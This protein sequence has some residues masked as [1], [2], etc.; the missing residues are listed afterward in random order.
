MRVRG[1]LVMAALLLSTCAKTA[2]PTAVA[3]EYSRALYAGEPHAIYRLIS[4]EDQRLRSEVDF[5]QQQEEREGF[6]G[7]L[8]AQLAS[9]IVAT[10]VETRV[11]NRRATVRLKLVLPNANA[12]EIRALAHD[13]DEWTLNAL[14]NDERRRIRDR[15]ADLHR[16]HALPTLEGDETFSLVQDATGWRV[17]TNWSQGVQLHFH[18][19]VPA[20]IPFQ[21]DVMPAQITVRP[22]EPVRVKVRVR[23]TGTHAVTMRVGHLIEPSAHSSFLALL[24][25]PLFLP[26]TLNP[27]ATEQFDSEYVL[28]KDLPGTVTEL[29]VTYRFL[30]DSAVAGTGAA[31]KDSPI[32]VSR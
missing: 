11:T 14:P 6:T 22:G 20:D 31:L 32:R 30:A 17:F 15:L 7:E 10:P 23:N 27:G 8:L 25:C 16:T 5:V 2:N 21:V 19:A 13:W 4:D 26:V 24:Q 1:V 29:G 3:I 12:P 9:F 28:L 18:A